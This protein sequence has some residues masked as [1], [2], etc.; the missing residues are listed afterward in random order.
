MANLSST[1]T[2]QALLLRAPFQQISSQPVLV[3]GVIHPQVQDPALAFVE[4]Q[5]FPL[6][7]FLQPVE[8]LLS[9]TAALWCISHSSQFCIISTLAEKAVYPFIQVTDG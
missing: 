9:G 8:I 5:E 4:C 2:P 6:C 3:H 1:G 7:P